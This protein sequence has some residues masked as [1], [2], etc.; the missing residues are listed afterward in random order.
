MVS[1]PPPVIASVVAT[2]P[3]EEALKEVAPAP[4]MASATPMTA[5]KEKVEPTPVVASAE[6]VEALEEGVA[7]APDVVFAPKYAL[8]F[9]NGYTKICSLG[10]ISLNDFGNFCI[11][12]HT[13]DNPVG[14]VRCVTPGH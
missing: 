1:A 14:F 9:C 11:F 7:P 3:V 5:L 4:N 10:H 13:W 6:M 12:Y 8:Q 2:T